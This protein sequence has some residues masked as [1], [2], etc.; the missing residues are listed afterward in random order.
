MKSRRA[1]V[2]ILGIAGAVLTLTF[3]CAGC[4]SQPAT[5]SPFDPPSS[6]DADLTNPTQLN[7]STIQQGQVLYHAADCVICHG[8]N[9]DGKGFD[10]KNGHMNVHDWRD[11]EYGR[12][13]TDGQLY[14]LIARGKDTM[15]AY[16]KHSTPD[17]IWLMVDFIRSLSMN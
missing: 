15:P 16:A 8:R 6:V 11:P 2:R 10:A 9:G 13:F 12:K 17:Q 1:S 3:L 4:G 7:A 5:P 14:A